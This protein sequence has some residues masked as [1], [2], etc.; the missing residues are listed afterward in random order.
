VIFKRIISKKKNSRSFFIKKNKKKVF[1][2]YNVIIN[3]GN[4]LFLKMKTLF[5]LLFLILLSSKIYAQHP[6]ATIPDFSFYKLDK[7]V[8]TNKNI[9]PGKLS[10]IIFFDA[11]CDH[12]Q[13][14]METYNQHYK[15]LSKT[16]IYL[17]TVDNPASINYFM[18]KYANNLYGSKNV[19]I[20]QDFK[21]E[22]ITK[23]G[24]RKYPS[25][26]L[27]SPQKKLLIYDDEPKNVG[28]FLQKI[29]ENTKK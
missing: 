10:L 27:Y 5:K 28:N 13:H 12:C 24:P 16:A 9:Q 11:S 29:K 26:F 21:N 8:F 22:F 19:T 2:K 3:P 14:A 7:T 20:L 25:M 17:V 4:P 18:T 1:Y 23:F 6:A 15:E